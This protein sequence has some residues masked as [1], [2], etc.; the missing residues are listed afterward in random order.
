MKK[1]I[2][3]LDRLPLFGLL[4]LDDLSRP[5]RSSRVCASLRQSSLFVVR[6]RMEVVCSLAVVAF[7]IVV[8][9]VHELSINF[10]ADA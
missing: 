4:A 3:P 9:T 8:S 5:T 1:R 10:V 6:H 7:S 2:R